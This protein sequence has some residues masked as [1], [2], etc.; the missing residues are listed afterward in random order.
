MKPQIFLRLKQFAACRRGAIMMMGGLMAAI[1]IGAGGAA[2][3]FGKQQ[4][5]YKNA[6]QAAD[7][8]A[9]SSSAAR[10][11]EPWGKVPKGSGLGPQVLA[12]QEARVASYY[13][14]NT[15]GYN[16]D[17]SFT[18]AI[19]VEEVGDVFR[20]TV[21]GRSAV[22]SGFVGVLGVSQ[23]PYTIETVTNLRNP[24]ETP[25]YDIVMLLD[26]TFS[27][28]ENTLDDGDT[29]IQ[30][31]RK[32][33]KTLN[34]F[35]MC[36]NEQGDRCDFEHENRVAMI[37]YGLTSIGLDPCDLPAG[38]PE[39]PAQCDCIKPRG[40]TLTDEEWQNLR[41][42]EGG[43]PET[44]RPVCDRVDASGLTASNPLSAHFNCFCIE[45]PL[46]CPDKDK[47]IDGLDALEKAF[48]DNCMPKCTKGGCCPSRPCNNFGPGNR[49]CMEEQAGSYPSSPCC[50]PRSVQCDGRGTPE[51]DDDICGVVPGP[52]PPQ[53]VCCDM[54]RCTASC[55]ATG[56][57]SDP[58]AGSP[59]PPRCVR[60]TTPRGTPPR[61][62][63][64]G[65][66][67]NEWQSPDMNRGWKMDTALLR[68]GDTQALFTPVQAGG[69][70]W[71]RSLMHCK[72]DGAAGCRDGINTALLSNYF[73]NN[74]NSA[75]AFDSFQRYRGYM[76]FMRP[77]R[78]GDDG[79]A[80][81]VVV[82]VTDGENNRFRIQEYG[83]ETPKIIPMPELVN[84]VWQ[85][86][87]TPGGL[88]AIKANRYTADG[89]Y[90]RPN[91]AS[92]NDPNIA[93]TAQ[94]WSDHFTLQHCRALRNRMVDGQSRPV[95]IYTVAV[96]SVGNLSTP[97]GRH[98][99]RLMTECSYGTAYETDKKPDDQPKQLFFAVQDSRDLNQA[100]RAIANSLGRIRIVD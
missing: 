44:C 12:Q 33:A 47:P 89:T 63:M 95:I 56:A 72:D 13:R 85:D 90:V 35:V 5:A 80:V 40:S 16:V 38:D 26:Y 2:F 51:E 67:F 78:D 69:G 94:G 83:S 53:T 7:L 66:G 73:E 37:P 50:A 17:P 22:A 10:L 9:T 27:M 49:G 74:T 43:M 76:D 45:A 65:L 93:K 91:N 42:H 61:P 24:G 97:A 32:A 30:A 4:M 60:P 100:F 87:L 62:T 34:E 1:L 82:W 75:S 77:N 81:P 41:G 57:P 23:L 28:V 25:Y 31:L 96:G 29:R 48:Y 14:L 19:Q 46:S 88:A 39:R 64:P 59:P 6:Q 18:P 11:H 71:A 99:A 98:T 54:E 70:V 58:C 55:S 68:E 52:M 92:Y 21:T 20:T 3:D 84:G 8:A 15:R 86:P 36:G 79:D